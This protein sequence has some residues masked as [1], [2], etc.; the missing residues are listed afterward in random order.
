MGGLAPRRMV[1][2]GRGQVA[3]P[4]AKPPTNSLVVPRRRVENHGVSNMHTDR[5]RPDVT[6]D[7]T[8]RRFPLYSARASRPVVRAA[9]RVLLMWRFRLFQRH[10]YRRL[11]IEE[12]T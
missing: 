4:S 11:I 1:R 7:E 3:V 2:A 5:N 8:I 10:R 6:M 12:V 9:W